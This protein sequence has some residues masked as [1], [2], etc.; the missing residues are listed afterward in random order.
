[1]H[2]LKNRAASLT[3]AAALTLSSGLAL[4]AATA[5]P[6]AA[7]QT[8]ATSSCNPKTDFET[9][10]PSSFLVWTNFCGT[11]YKDPIDL[12]KIR[13]ATTPYHRVWLHNSSGHS[14]CFWGGSD[15][16]VPVAFQQPTNMLVS[17]NTSPC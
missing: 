5:G 1:M 7:A 3:A 16:D 15:K 2:M 8:P 14:W 4:T 9:L 6:A 13:D 11:G 10:N 12:Y 17:A